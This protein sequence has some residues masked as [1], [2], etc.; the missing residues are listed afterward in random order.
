MVD[1]HLPFTISCYLPVRFV[2]VLPPIPEPLTSFI[3]C[4]YDPSGERQEKEYLLNNVAKL[5][6]RE[7]SPEIRKA[8]LFQI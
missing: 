1:I 8:S 4:H 7:K 5:R 3:H 2:E 6:L